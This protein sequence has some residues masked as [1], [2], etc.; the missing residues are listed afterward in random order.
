MAIQPLHEKKDLKTY[1][2][3]LLCVRVREGGSEGDFG[4]VEAEGSKER[5]AKLKEK[6][7]T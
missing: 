4:R 3:A 1:P 6:L 5:K 7:P 2:I